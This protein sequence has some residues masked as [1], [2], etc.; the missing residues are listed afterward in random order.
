MPE[1]EQKLGIRELRF[2]QHFNPFYEIS[3]NQLFREDNLETDPWVLENYGKVTV[4][5]SKS[6][7]GLLKDKTFN[8][9]VLTVE[10]DVSKKIPPEEARRLQERLGLIAIIND[11][12]ILL[13]LPTITQIKGVPRKYLF[14][15]WGRLIRK[16]EESFGPPIE[17][18]KPLIVGGGDAVRSLRLKFDLSDRIQAF[19]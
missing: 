7:R 17:K 6:K 1:Q 15:R 13:A 12:T 5:L 2:G 10:F 4:R 3:A 9:R 11:E 19:T 18:P 14:E 8:P 16:N